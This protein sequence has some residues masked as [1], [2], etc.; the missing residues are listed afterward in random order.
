M[1]SMPLSQFTV[2]DIDSA[3]VSVSGFFPSLYSINLEDHP[4]NPES[5]L[6]LLSYTMLGVAHPWALGML[7][8]QANSIKHYAESG[9][10]D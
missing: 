9:G 6:V 3:D 7:A 4:E 2:S 1:L 8:Y 10:E 5:T